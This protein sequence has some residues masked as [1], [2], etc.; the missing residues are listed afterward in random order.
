MV[1]IER[2]GDAVLLLTIDRPDR[3]NAVDVA[4]LTALTA[5]LDG[6][7]D[8]DVRVVVLTGAPP[9]FCAGADLGGAESEEFQSALHSALRALA[10]CPL[11]VI[12][13]VDG[14]A[15]G[16]GTQ[17]VSVCDLRVATERSTFGIPAARL[18]LAV[19]QWTVDRMVGEFGVGIARAM[20]VAA[21]VF[22]TT[23]LHAAGPV[24]RV[25]DLGV[26][27][28][29]ADRVAALAPLTMAAH[30]AML[31]EAA[32]RVDGSGFTEALRRAVWSSDDAREGPAAFLE[33][34]PPRFRGR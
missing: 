14:P 33:K 22:D 30:K 29:W 27:L 7:A 19:D 26:A 21:E 15:L 10:D 16:A 24:H 3:R 11:P 8:S 25:G 6:V 20:L 5:A 32:R 4:T 13:A 2:P 18:G 31:T 12:A 1:R 9:A 34:R 23:R 17:L 28:D